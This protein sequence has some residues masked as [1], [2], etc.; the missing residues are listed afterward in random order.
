MPY[1]SYSEYKTLRKYSKVFTIAKQCNANVPWVKLS[2]RRI[3]WVVP[4]V[5][6]AAG[7]SQKWK[8]VLARGHTC[9]YNLHSLPLGTEPNSIDF[10]F[11]ICFCTYHHALKILTLLAAIDCFIM[12]FLGRFFIVKYG[13]KAD[14]PPIRV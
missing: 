7:A 13:R 2:T 8:P 5:F 14:D 9:L 3:R 10:T 6:A 1:F 11:S 12:L 4:Q